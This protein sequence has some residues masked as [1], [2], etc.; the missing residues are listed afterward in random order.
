MMITG[1]M[2]SNAA[3]NGRILL[4]SYHSKDKVNPPL[5]LLNPP[6]VNLFWKILDVFPNP[7]IYIDP[8]SAAGRERAIDVRLSDPSEIYLDHLCNLPKSAGG[9]MMGSLRDLCGPVW[10][11]RNPM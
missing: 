9:R 7:T 11:T 1:L 3:A 2:P 10:I 6:L 4:A 5:I 8:G